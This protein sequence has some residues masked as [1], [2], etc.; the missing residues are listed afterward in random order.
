MKSSART[1]AVL[2]AVTIAFSLTGCV[3]DDQPLD[4]TE[5]EQ[6]QSGLEEADVDL[7]RAKTEIEDAG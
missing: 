4:G 3:V 6:L 7:E 2:V 1:I 5:Q